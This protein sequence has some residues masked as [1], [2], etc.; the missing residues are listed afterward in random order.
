MSKT[1]QP[2]V[3]VQ[4]KHGDYSI[5]SASLNGDGDYV[6]MV[7]EREDAQLLGAAPDLLAF[8]EAFLRSWTAAGTTD[9]PLEAQAR[10]AIAKATS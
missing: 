1:P 9:S 6:A 8:A 7:F 10:A 3:T 5:Q 4:T 2:W